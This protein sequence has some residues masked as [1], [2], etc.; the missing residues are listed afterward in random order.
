MF[1]ACDR[2]PK[3]DFALWNKPVKDEQGGKFG[4]KCPEC[5]SLLAENGGRVKCSE[6][7]CGFYRPRKKEKNGI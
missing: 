4:E 5:G 2:F 1:Y 3:C 6:K 7:N